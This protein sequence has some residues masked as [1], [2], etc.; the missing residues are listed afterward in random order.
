MESL[1]RFCTSGRLPVKSF[2]G[3]YNSVNWVSLRRFRTNDKLPVRLF[4]ERS[5]AES[6]LRLLNEKGTWAR[7]PLLERNKTSN[8]LSIPSLEGIEERVKLFRE[9][10]R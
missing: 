8:L 1:V 9:R 5:K 10:E 4:L 7:K 6:M 2:K 3:R